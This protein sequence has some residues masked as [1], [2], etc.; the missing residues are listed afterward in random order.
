MRNKIITREGLLELFKTNRPSQVGFTSGSFD[1]IH[2][3]HV[4]YLNKAKELCQCLVV[5]VNSDASIKAYKSE[6]RPIVPAESRAKVVAGLESVDYVFIFDELN[7]NENISQLKPDFYI[8]AAD[9]SKKTLSSAPIVE[10]YGGQVKLIDLVESSSSSEIIN[11]I[12]EKYSAGLQ[13]YTPKDKLPLSKAVI[14]D[15]D[16][17]INEHVEYLFEPDKFVL[18]A[19]AIAGIKAFQDAG[20]RV[21]IITNQPGV[22][23]GYFQFE[24]LF[25]VNKKMLKLLSAEGILVDKIYFSPYTKAAGTDCRKPNLG[26]IRRA[27]KELNLDLKNSVVIG[28]SSGD[29]KMGRDAG[30]KTILVQTGNA[31]SDN[32][33]EV[34]ADYISM[35]LLEAA[36]FIIK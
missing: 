1:L 19:N 26:L 23:F 22:D 20:Y 8:K 21:V 4:D 27:E 28:D 15:R 32:L 16:G 35:D 17:T 11:S 7:N 2:P 30:C 29:I 24:D 25:K 18:L 34:Q 5:G 12:L 31:G 36:K 6:L 3:G 9:Y 14:L 13:A 33:Y 10:S